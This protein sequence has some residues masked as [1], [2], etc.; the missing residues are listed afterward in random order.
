MKTLYKD[1]KTAKLVQYSYGTLY[2]SDLNPATDTSRGNSVTYLEWR[3][4]RWEML[5]LGWR[6][7]TAALAWRMP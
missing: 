1:H 5:R 2:M 4:G 7:I 3:M 6:I